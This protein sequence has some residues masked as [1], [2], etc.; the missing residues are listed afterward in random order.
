MKIEFLPVAKLEL[1]DAVAYYDLELKGLGSR[2]KLEV[3]TSLKRIAVFPKAW[4]LIKPDIRRCIMHKFPYN[5]LY[6]IEE[7]T[8][9]IIAVAH[10]HRNPEYWI[11][12]T[13]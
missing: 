5:I 7:D 6:A 11:D 4:T 9:L 12:R 1:D 8:I 3:K 13:R 10:H 2:F